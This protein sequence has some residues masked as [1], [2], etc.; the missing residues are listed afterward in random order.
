MEKNVN[1]LFGAAQTEELL[2][3][4]ALLIDRYHPEQLICF[5]SKVNHTTSAGCFT[6]NDEKQESH[7]FLLMI[8]E[9][10]KRVEHEAQDFVNTHSKEFNHNVHI[11]IIA[12]SWKTVEAAVLQGCRFFITVCRDGNVLYDAGRLSLGT[13]YAEPDTV[14]LP[15]GAERHYLHRYGMSTGFMEAAK[16]CYEKGFYYNAAFLLHQATEQ[17]CN[18]LMRVFI[19]YRSDLHSLNRLLDLSL[20][21]AEEPSA[22]FPRRTEDEKRL[23]RL[24]ANSY[25]AARYKDDFQVSRQDVAVL[26]AQVEAF[27]ATTQEL[28]LRRMGD[29]RLAAQEAL[30]KLADIS[31]A[32]PAALMN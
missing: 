5:G 31:P 1:P 12:H 4:T 23:F 32:L 29:Y 24:L 11:T 3:I 7:Y 13:N 15:A 25:S 20:C 8:T 16:T 21:F 9:F 14:A 27:L 2:T 10:T 18:A 6:E 19:A 26:L 22:C 30:E 28:C 17:A